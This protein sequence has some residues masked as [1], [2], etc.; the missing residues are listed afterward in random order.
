MNAVV[1]KVSSHYDEVADIYDYRYDAN[2]GKFYYNDISRHVMEWFPK[3]GRLLDLGCGTGL[4]VRHYVNEGGVAVGIDISR[5]MIGK[6]SD[7]CASSDFTIGTA[8]VLPFCDG[9]FDAVS[10]LLSFSYL[11]QPEMALAETF[12]VLRPGSPIA[13]CTLGRNLFT[14]GLPA[15]YHISEA[16]N[17]KK[18]CFGAFGERYYSVEEMEQLF[19]GA[20]FID[21]RVKRC[22]FAH[23]NLARPIY[24]LA[25][26]IEP[27]VE[28]NIPYLAYNICASGRKPYDDEMESL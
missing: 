17:L 14:R 2:S 3:G 4:F 27:F 1:N 8:E 18:A 25:K 16:M 11:N 22:S 15:L 26:K 10:S 5:G 13:V 12:R 24:V 19:Y 6:A 20:G 21:V 9:S 23:Y 7:K 28:R